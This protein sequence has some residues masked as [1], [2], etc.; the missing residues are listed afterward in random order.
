MPTEAR[1]TNFRVVF[2]QFSDAA[3]EEDNGIEFSNVTV[4]RKAAA[5]EE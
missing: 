2:A 1:T 3:V 4:E 5:K